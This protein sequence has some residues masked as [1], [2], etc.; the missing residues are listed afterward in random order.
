MMPETLRYHRG[1][2]ALEV[3]DQ[4]ALPFQ[5]RHLRCR[6]ASQVAEAIESMAVR[7]AP[8]IG[9]AAAFGLALEALHAPEG[10]PEAAERL[11]RS[12]PTAVNL[13]WALERMRPLFPLPPEERAEKMLAEAETMLEEDRER[14]RRMGAFG[15]SLLP[16]T[17]RVITHCN[18]GALATGGFG[19]A[20]GVLRAA[21]EQG[22][23]LV[24]YADETRPR[25]QGARLTAFEL[26]EEGFSFQVLC[27][28]MAAALMRTRGVDA[29]ITGAD[30]IARNGDCANKIGTYGLAI[31]ARHHRIPFYVAAP[32][33]TV[34]PATPTG[35][36]SPIEERDASEVRRMGE[37]R[38]F[39]D[40]YPVWNPAFDVTP[41]ELV[42]AIVTET[43]I[44][45]PPYEESI[46]GYGKNH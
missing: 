2:E 8:A 5:V 20:L 14:N 32:W 26:F 38:L 11:A 15:A 29:V 6:R 21:R 41:A 45:R 28:G 46:A 44:L 18:A 30:R 43:G 39:P 42:T 34:D 33:S 13:F 1:E 3:L 24:V 17:A 35:D 40:A 22:K 16:Q 19:T 9:L 23:E 37:E 10:L 25:L 27:D 12:R 36:Q 31:C 4:R 7:G